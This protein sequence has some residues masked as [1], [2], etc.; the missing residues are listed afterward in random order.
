M[1]LRIFLLASLMCV[2]ASAENQAYKESCP[3]GEV[4][5]AGKCMSNDAAQ[6]VC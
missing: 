2:S 5:C 4:Y 6:K 1:F 3:S